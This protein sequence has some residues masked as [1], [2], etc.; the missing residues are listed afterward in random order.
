MK[1]GATSFGFRYSFMDPANSPK[2]TEV[3]RQC[4]EASVERLQVCEN[5]RPFELSK[6]EWAEGRRCA[7]DR[8]IMVGSS[9]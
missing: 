3:I 8:G 1:I 2:R 6:A 5:V 4:R 7:A 9:L